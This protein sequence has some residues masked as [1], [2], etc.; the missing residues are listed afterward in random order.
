MTAGAG[1]GSCR[2]LGVDPHRPELREE[3]G[4]SS[5]GGPFRFVRPVNALAMHGGR[6]VGDRF[7][8]TREPGGVRR[9]VR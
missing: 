6:K 3:T 2:A 8:P 7:I 1:R 5:R 9:L 4:R